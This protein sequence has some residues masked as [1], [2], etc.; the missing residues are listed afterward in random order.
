MV[1]MRWPA[2]RFG[3]AGVPFGKWEEVAA[4]TGWGAGGWGEPGL[5]GI[6]C[7]HCLGHFVIGF[8]DNM[9]GATISVVFPFFLSSHDSKGPFNT[10]WG[11]EQIP[12]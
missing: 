4:C 5:V 11:I 1:N 12:V 10:I 8:E 9:L 7:P 3:L 6:S 2:G